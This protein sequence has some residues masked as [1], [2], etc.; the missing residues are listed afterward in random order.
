M[1][2]FK[3]DV[4]EITWKMIRETMPEPKMLDA[5]I[6]WELDKMY[7]ASS[8]TNHKVISGLEKKFYTDLGLKKCKKSE[9]HA[10]L[11]V[12]EKLDGL[13]IINKTKNYWLKPAKSL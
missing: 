3:R 13:F 1:T 9:A 12:G 8:W 10:L 6:C 7:F 2:E 4:D 11:Q 5:E